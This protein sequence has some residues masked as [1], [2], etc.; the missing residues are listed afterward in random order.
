[1]T[2]FRRPSATLLLAFLVIVTAIVVPAAKTK[3]VTNFDK[4]FDFGAV[5]TWAWTASGKG[6]VKMA[7][8]ADDNPDAVQRQYEPVIVSGVESA[9]AK[10]GITPASGSPDV[11]VTYYLLISSGASTQEMGQFVQ[12]VPEWGLPPLSG[13]TTSFRVIEQGSLVLDV[14]DPKS[15]VVWRSVARG[16]IKLDRTPEERSRRLAELIQEMLA[17]FPPKK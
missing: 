7:L 17:K 3:I 12:S 6:Q 5:K 4:A 16:E 1:M 2:P 14:L 8:T 10:R 13:P 15:N 11:Q 9:L